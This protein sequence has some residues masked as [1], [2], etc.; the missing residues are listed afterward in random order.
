MNS[1]IENAAKE[2]A[3]SYAAQE[4]AYNYQG[5][6]KREYYAA[7]I[8]QGMAASDYWAENFQ[9]KENYL[10][11]A[12]ENAVAAADALIIALCPPSNS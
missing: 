2:P 11:M 9:Q 12:A 4:G 1:K 5:L 6:S 8:L 7:Q 10:Q 3:F